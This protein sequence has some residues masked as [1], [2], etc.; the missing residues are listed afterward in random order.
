MKTLFRLLVLVPAALILLAFALANR[1][2]VSVSFDPL[3][4]TAARFKIDLPLFLVVFAM[5][6][7]GILV[8]GIAMWFSQG[9]H[10]RAERRCRKEVERLRNELA[11]LEGDAAHL[12]PPGRTFPE[13]HAA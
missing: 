6:M 7:F 3:Q 9:K 1:Q 13:S 12:E 4:E 2:I 8:G 11:R 5:V 10:R